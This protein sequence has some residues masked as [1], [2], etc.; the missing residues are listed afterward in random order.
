[1]RQ[2]LGLSLRLYPAALAVLTF[3]PF[4]QAQT[5]TN[6]APRA[7]VKVTVGMYGYDE[8]QH[9]AVGGAF[10]YY[11]FSQANVELEGLYILP[12]E[13]APID[14]FRAFAL[15]P[16][17]GVDSRHPPVN[18]QPY[19]RLAY[20]VDHSTYKTQAADAQPAEK[21]RETNGSLGVRFGFKFYVG[22]RFFL[23]PEFGMGEKLLFKAT[24]SAGY[25]TSVR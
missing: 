4:L 14:S 21:K 10:A 22:D 20:T 23:Y 9:P 25:V 2:I 18:F 1:M 17:F 6:R 8:D 11:P 7:E 3:S 13:S 24:L 16:S 19:G 5:Q 12:S 15:T